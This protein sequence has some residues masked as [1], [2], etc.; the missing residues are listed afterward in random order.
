MESSEYMR[1]IGVDPSITGFASVILD[2]NGQVL[3]EISIKG[4]DLPDPLRMSTIVDE[5][6]ENIDKGETLFIEGFAYGGKVG[7]GTSKAYGIGWLLRDR[8]I[9]K[10]CFFLD[11][12]PTRLKK[13]A[14]NNGRAKKPEVIE[15]VIEQFNYN[16][17][18]RSNRANSPYN[19][20]LADA[21]VLASMCF[22]YYQTYINKGETSLY[23]YQET[24]LKSIHADINDSKINS[25][26]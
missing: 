8:L 25:T 18:R 5:F 21:Y 23:P 16:V 12:A 26:N 4:K 19:D 24:V 3:K 14:T 1:F 7:A 10:G 22:N 15:S 20:D 9:K 13:Y 2:S 11:V 17:P 6:M